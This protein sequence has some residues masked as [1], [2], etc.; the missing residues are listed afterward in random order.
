MQ[1]HRLVH[2]HGEGTWAAISKQLNEGTRHDKGRIGKQVGYVQHDMKILEILHITLSFFSG[3]Q[4]Y[5][6]GP[7]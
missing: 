3:G 5:M 6:K 2:A 7:F 1:L 4:K